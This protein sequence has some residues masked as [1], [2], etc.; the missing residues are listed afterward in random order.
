MHERPSSV[1][2]KKK[3]STPATVGGALLCL[4]SYQP[5]DVSW[6]THY[7]PSSSLLWN[8]VSQSCLWTLDP[9]FSVAPHLPGLDLQMDATLL[10]R[11]LSF[12]PR[13]GK[14]LQRNCQSQPGLQLQTLGP[15]ISASGRVLEFM[16]PPEPTREANVWDRH[17]CIQYITN[18][19]KL[20][21][22]HI[23]KR[24]H[25]IGMCNLKKFKICKYPPIWS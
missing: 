19:L 15:Q 25:E 23:Y 4:Q 5:L 18:S 16:L 11:P 3:E 7:Q 22:K 20:W 14:N 8:M 21:N 1:A 10:G 17:V 24:V 13:I 6:A 2:Q 12:C 9:L